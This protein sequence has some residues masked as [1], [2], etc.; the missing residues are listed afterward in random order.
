LGKHG[1][2]VV[3]S[4]LLP[5]K[6]KNISFEAPCFSGLI[7]TSLPNHFHFYL[8][9][10]KKTISGL[11]ITTTEKKERYNWMRSTGRER[12]AYFKDNSVVCTSI[13]IDLHLFVIL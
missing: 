10:R 12:T 6:L 11:P 5:K 1:A 2:Q 3:S 8:I 4:D 13:L 7:Y 9:F